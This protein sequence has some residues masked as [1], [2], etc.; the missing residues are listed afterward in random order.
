MAPLPTGTVTFLF[1]DLEGSTALW[2]RHPD[3]MRVALARHDELLRELVE[4]NNGAVFKMVGDACC[5]AFAS[6]PDA[7]AAAVAAQRALR[8]RDW[9]ELGRLSVRISIHTGAAEETRGDYVGPPVNRVARLLAAGHGGQILVS[10]TSAGLVAGSLPPGCELRDLGLHRLKDLIDPERIHE[11]AGPGLDERFPPL[12]TL[13]ARQTNLPIQATRL[14]GRVQELEAAGRLLADEDVRLVTLTGPGGT[15]KTRLALQLGAEAL[16]RYPDGVYFVELSP[17]DDP[18]LV[19]ATIAQALAL[20]ESP[21]HAFADSL[22]DYLR[23]RNLLLV[24]DNLEQLLA[25]APLFGRLLGGSPGLNLLVTSRAPLRLSGEHEFAVAPLELPPPQLDSVPDLA[26]YDAVALFVERARAVDAGFVLDAENARAVAEICARLDGLPLAL[27]LAAARVKLLRPTQLLPRLEHALA[28]L[29]RGARD[30]PGRHQTLRETIAWSFRLLDPAEQALFARLSVFAGGCSLEAAEALC[31]SDVLEHLASL[32]DK[33]LIRRVEAASGEPRYT[34][35]ATIREFASECLEASGKA[36]EAREAHAKHVLAFAEEVEPALNAPDQA[37]AMH[38]VADEHEN[39]RA[40]LTWALEQRNAEL[41][42]RI[43]GALVV[44]FSLRGHLSEGRAWLERAIAEGES[45]ALAKAVNGLGVLAREQGDYDRAQELFAENLP[46]ARAEG[47]WLLPRALMN[48]GAIA[49]YRGEYERAQPLFEESRREALASG[50]DSALS[51]S[52]IRLGVLA[53]SVADIARAREH[54][55]EGLA[56]ERR[57]GNPSAVASLL[58]NLGYLAV[59]EGDHARATELSE[60]SMAI[61][62]TLGDKRGVSSPLLNLSL[63]ALDSG[64]H[65]RAHALLCEAATLRAELG[66]RLG[67]IECLESL[68]RVAAAAGEHE[69]AAQSLGAGEALRATLRAPLSPAERETQA[70]VLTALRERLGDTHFEDAWTRGGTLSLEEA[71]EH[72]VAARPAT[73][74]EG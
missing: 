27:E 51:T 73:S 52:L 15:G 65:P 32:V 60:E 50:D 35:L 2:E 54:W 18:E 62:E 10:G 36:A 21:G 59:V 26:G 55:E 46:R 1:T 39:V 38:R 33:S 4:S 37:A 13:D 66:D 41:A 31:G 56:V 12:R 49:L 63:V 40:A 44:F 3:A 16:D 20:K 57:R 29:T 72:A 42:Q 8:E 9:G 6:A 67:L 25:A 61:C 43:A 28:I 11:V 53:Y 48:L 47:G 45:P 30:A 5:A 69:C 23:D 24:L 22:Q 34:M 71:V 58:N 74:P 17:I 64:D 14:V 19:P 7:L 68:G 70:P